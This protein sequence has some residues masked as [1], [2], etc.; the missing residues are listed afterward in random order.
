MTFVMTSD[1]R[2]A[3]ARVDGDASS[4]DEM[5]DA[6]ARGGVAS[7]DVEFVVGHASRRRAKRRVRARDRARGDARGRR[8]GRRVRDGVPRRSRRGRGRERMGV[9]AFAPAFTAA[10][11][12]G[13][14]DARE[15]NAVVRGVV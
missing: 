9:E 6:R 14:T 10:R 5:D 15:R 13:E 7:V 4:D 8:L 11:R 2:W 1:G 3:V 12:T